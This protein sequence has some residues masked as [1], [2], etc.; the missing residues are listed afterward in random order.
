MKNE[1]EKAKSNPIDRAKEFVQT[2]LDRLN[3]KKVTKERTRD[4]VKLDR[5]GLAKG[6]NTLANGG[7]VG[8]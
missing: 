3:H 1:K 5:V 4:R 7:K 2:L 6:S 8:K